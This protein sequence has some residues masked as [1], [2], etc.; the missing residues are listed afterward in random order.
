MMPDRRDCW[1]LCIGLLWAAATLAAADPGRAAP[2]KGTPGMAEILAAS[3]ASAWRPL[4]DEHTMYMELPAGR[5]IVEL[6]PALAPHTVAGDR[7]A[8]AHALFRQRRGGAGA[9]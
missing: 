3:P 4:V 9:G 8:G 2:A 5:V 7:S 1:I 6:E